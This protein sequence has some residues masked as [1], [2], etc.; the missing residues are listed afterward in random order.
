MKYLSLTIGTVAIVAAVLIAGCLS[1]S[2]VNASADVAVSDDETAARAR[3]LWEKV[4]VAK[5][6]RARL[7]KITNLYVAAD[8]GQG[9][10]ESTL[11]VFP[12]YRFDFSYE[13]KQEE[14][15]IEVSNARKGIVWWQILDKTKPRK[16]EAEDVY[17][18]LRPQFIYLLVTSDVDPVPLGMRKEWIGL[19]RV[20]VI[21]VEAQGWRVDYYIDPKTHLP[22]RVVLPNGLKAH[23]RGDMNHIV[24]LEDYAAVDGVMMPHKATHTFTT[25][26]RKLVDRLK[27]EINAAYD[28]QVFEQAPTS[29]TSGES[30]RAKK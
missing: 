5:G 12:D 4:L 19:K 11:N 16:Y 14:T 25:N 3:E 13:P 18:N 17:R 26:P 10:R 1:P 9:Y 28:P 29:R 22:L 21:E 27:F 23:E 20:D 8:Q 7:R 24:T 6:G 15:S 30:W 2:K